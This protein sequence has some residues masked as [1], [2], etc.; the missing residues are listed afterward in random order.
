MCCDDLDKR[1]ESNL[2]PVNDPDCVYVTVGISSSRDYVSLTIML[3]S[4][5]SR[6]VS[7]DAPEAKPVDVD[8]ELYRRVIINFGRGIGASRLA[9]QALLQGGVDDP[10]LRQDLLEGIDDQLRSMSLILDN[11]VQFNALRRNALLLDMKPINLQQWLPPFLAKW[12]LLALR[13]GFVWREELVPDSL[14]VRADPERLA[15]VMANLLSN[16][17][18]HTPRGGDAVVGLGA[19]RQDAWISI[20]NSGPGLTS[21][22]CRRVF[23]PFFASARQGRFPR[24]VG[25]GLAVAKGLVQAQ[26]GRIEFESDAGQGCSFSIWLPLIRSN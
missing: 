11:L 4:T 13:E 1:H 24:G 9:T 19:T 2:K 10:E 5:I 7:R 3:Q 26:N 23:E 8:S 25:L 6:T 20:S 14:P 12:R 16:V 21:A 15:Q 22:D 17:V 18:Q